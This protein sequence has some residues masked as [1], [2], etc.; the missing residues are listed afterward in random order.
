[1][2]QV[3]FEEAEE[4]KSAGHLDHFPLSLDT[5]HSTLLNDFIYKVEAVIIFPPLIVSKCILYGY[6]S[7]YLKQGILKEQ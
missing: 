3:G 7:C 1:M 4:F 5:E 2:L 6:G